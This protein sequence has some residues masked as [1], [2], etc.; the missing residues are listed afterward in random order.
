[1]SVIIQV[2][3]GFGNHL[4]SFYLGTILA[5][6]NNMK[7]SINGN[8]ISND[9]NTQRN[10]TRTTIY[11]LIDSTHVGT[12][13]GGG[14]CIIS[15][16][17]DYL[18]YMEGYLH[19]DTNYV[20]DF[21]PGSDLN[22]SFFLDYIQIIKKYIINDIYTIDEDMRNS[23][24][25]SLR[26]GMGAAEIA[27]PSPFEY[28]LR[29]PFK[30]YNNAINKCLEMNDNIKKIFILSDNYTDEYI[31]HFDIFKDRF[32]LIYCNTKNT[33]EQFKYIV[34]AQYC[35]SSNSSFSIMSS[36]LNETGVVI[37]PNFK[38]SD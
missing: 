1:M 12:P 16:I 8:S 4:I 34:N 10:D 23:I 7:L 19:K 14:R 36:I 13:T 15:S 5:N 9:S 3:G 28:A 31:N 24:I 20:M 22:M 18:N 2:H 6:K 33:Y 21:L 35:I 25:I 30:Y 37:F 29:L 27:Q 32:Q 17:K 11:K 26:L 38:E